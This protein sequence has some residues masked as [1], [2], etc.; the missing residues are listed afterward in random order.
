MERRTDGVKRK[1][2]KE[3]GEKA[4]VTAISRLKSRRVLYLVVG[5]SNWEG[6]A[7]IRGGE[8]SIPFHPEDEERKKKHRRVSPVKRKRADFFAIPRRLFRILIKGKGVKDKC[9]LAI[10]RLK[11]TKFRG[12]KSL[13][14]MTICGTLLPLVET[15]HFRDEDE[16]IRRIGDVWTKERICTRRTMEHCLILFERNLLTKIKGQNDAR[17]VFSV[18]GIIYQTSFENGSMLSIT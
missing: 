8:T 1:G 11:S 5:L 16:I 6:E 17:I 18:V 3:G 9:R 12:W 13:G 2:R 14:S 7:S 10:S 4:R 15:F